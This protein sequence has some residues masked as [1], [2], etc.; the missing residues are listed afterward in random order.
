M[1]AGVAERWHVAVLVDNRVKN[2]ADLKPTQLS[3]VSVG[4]QPFRSYCF[5]VSL[6]ACISKTCVKTSWRTLDRQGATGIA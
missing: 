2:P 5:S 3:S 4:A 6:V 1:S